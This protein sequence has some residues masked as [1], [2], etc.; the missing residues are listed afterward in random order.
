MKKAYYIIAAIAAITTISCQ[1]SNEE[2]PPVDTNKKIEL[3]PTI[4]NGK[5]ISNTTKAPQLNEDG[6][7]N[8]TNGDVITLHVKSESGE[9]TLVK[10]G[11]GVTNLYWKDINLAPN[12]NM[13]NFSA[14]Y[15]E[16]TII[17]GKFSFDLETAANKDLLWAHR[18]S[19]ST[20]TE[21]AIDMPFRHVMHRLVIK[22]TT[23]SNIDVDQIQTIC[24]AK[25]TCE[26]DLAAESLDCHASKKANFS[27]KGNTAVFTIIPQQTSDV[28]LLVT[29]GQMHK[30]FTL[31]TLVTKFDNLE[32]GMQLTV[33]LTIKDG[34]IVF[35]ESTITPWEDQGTIEGEIIL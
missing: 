3:R 28:S 33:N 31:D 6:S 4:V 14:C 17:D 2:T 23:Q 30:E 25:S 7:G 20:A 26:I 1:K 18:K 29:V 21:T 19:I 12:D 5:N 8:F 13:V 32:S 11:V 24:T 15:P 16:Q 34:S 22:F 27:A 35:E 9:T 10:Y